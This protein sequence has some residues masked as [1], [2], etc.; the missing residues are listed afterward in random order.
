MKVRVL[1]ISLV[2][3]N[4]RVMSFWKQNSNWVNALLLTQLCIYIFLKAFASI[5]FLFAVILFFICNSQWLYKV[6]FFFLFLSTFPSKTGQSKTIKIFLLSSAIVASNEMLGEKSSVDY[7]KLSR[8]SRGGL[9]AD[10]R[11]KYRWAF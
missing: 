11:E 2:I 5:I 9:P 10:G 7:C 4:G 8:G 3:V 6:S 1:N